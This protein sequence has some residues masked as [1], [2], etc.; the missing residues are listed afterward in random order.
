MW[1]R[2][3][4]K[5]IF[6]WQETTLTIVCCMWTS[7]TPIWSTVPSPNH[8]LL[9]SRTW[10][11]T[12]WHSK[13]K[14]YDFEAIISI[15]RNRRRVCYILNFKKIA[16]LKA[17]DCSQLGLF[18]GMSLM[19]FFEVFE[20]IIELVDNFITSQISSRRVKPGDVKKTSD[21]V[22]RF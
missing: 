5:A 9:L 7:S 3:L 6:N 15:L 22:H 17:L 16:K 19:T 2:C 21:F 14:L 18:L 20:F 11:V 1:S 12:I 13:L 4:M 8:R 10:L